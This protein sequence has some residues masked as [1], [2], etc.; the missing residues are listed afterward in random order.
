MISKIMKISY[1]FD[2]SNIASLNLNPLIP[3]FFSSSR[4]IRRKF[5]SILILGCFFSSL[6]L[7]LSLNVGESPTNGYIYKLHFISDY[8]SYCYISI[9]SSISQWTLRI[10]PGQFH[11][12]KLFACAIRRIIVVASWFRKFYIQ[13]ISLIALCKLSRL[14]H[15]L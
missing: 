2:L 10:N 8:E 14:S 1:G 15:L 12:N 7:G 11:L 9:I 5:F 13:S 6:A 4:S 3:I